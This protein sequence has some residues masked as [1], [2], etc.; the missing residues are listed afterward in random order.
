MGKEIGECYN[1]A[2]LTEE[3]APKVLHGDPEHGGLRFVVILV[4][5]FNLIAGFFLI[6]LILNIFFANTRIIEFATVLSC[7]F[8]IPFALAISYVVEIFLK[9]EWPSGKTLTLDEYK[10]TYSFPKDIVQSSDDED[11]QITVNWSERVNTLY[12]YFSLNGYPR[13]GRERRLSNKWFGLA[14]QIQQNDSRLVVYAYLPP[15]AAQNLT[16]NDDLS[17]PFVKISLAE[18]YSQAGQKR[19]HSASNRP[20]I[21][22]S[23]LTSGEGRYWLAEQKRWQSGLELNQEDFKTFI[24]Y[25]EDKT[26]P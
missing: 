1:S 17:E 20:K 8:S 21:D 7:T 23:L 6:Q 10:L 5:V 16:E 9:K 22:P 11:P 3:Y 18:L 24:A 15:Q 19:R 26:T 12:W 13:A 2:M 4:L 14:C 25:V